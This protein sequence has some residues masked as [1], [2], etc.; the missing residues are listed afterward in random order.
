MVLDN[1]HEL[2]LDL[3]GSFMGQIFDESYLKTNQKIIVRVNPPNPICLL[4][5]AIGK[6]REKK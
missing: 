1:G 6:P 5:I 2:V 4:H 3:L